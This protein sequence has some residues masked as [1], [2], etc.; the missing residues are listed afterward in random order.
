MGSRNVSNM[1]SLCQKNIETH[2]MDNLM[3]VAETKIKARYSI[4]RDAI[5]AANRFG[6]QSKQNP[7][8]V[9]QLQLVQ[10]MNQRYDEAQ[11]RNPA[12]RAITLE[13]DAKRAWRL[14]SSESRQ[15]LN[16]PSGK[17][18]WPG[19]EDTQ[20][21]SPTWAYADPSTGT[22]ELVFLGIGRPAFSQKGQKAGIIRDLKLFSGILYARSMG[23]TNITSSFYYL[24]KTTDNMNNVV[25]TFDPDFFSNTGGN[26]VSLHDTYK[27]VPNETDKL[28]ANALEQLKV[29]IDPEAMKEEDCEKCPKFDICQYTLP[30]TALIQEEVAVKDLSNLHLTNDQIAAI[31]VTNGVWRINAGAGAGKTMV[32]A[33]RV[34]KLLDAGVQP[35]EILLITFTT[36]GAKEMRER[37]KLVQEQIGNNPVEN[38]DE[39]TIC[40]F[41]AFGDLIIGDHYDLLGY[42][43]KPRVINDVN[44][45][46]IIDRLLRDHP[47]TSWTGSG[48]MQYDNTQNRNSALKVIS[49]IFGRIR[50]MNVDAAQVTWNDIMDVCQGTDITSHAAQE[51]IN[52]Y[53]FYADELKKQGLI[54]FVDQENFP[55]TIMELDPAY[56]SNR[57]FFKHIIVDEFQDSNEQQINLLKELIKLPTYQSL[58]VVGDDSQA[59]YGFRDTSPEYIIHFDKWIGQ[60]VNDIFLTDNHRSTPEIIDFANTINDLN[61]DKVEKKLVATR[62]HGQPVIVNA[63]YKKDEETNFIVQTIVNKLKDGVK[64]EQ[65][66]IICKTKREL[67]LYADLLTKAQVPAV[68]LAPERLMSNSRI[69]AILAF[70]RALQDKQDTR[71][72]LI[73]ANS[74]V[75]GAIMD[76]PQTK[77]DQLLTSLEQR[78]DTINAARSMQAKK[79]GFF[80][81]I[82]AIS[83]DDETV[84][85]F[86]ETLDMM[87][88]GEILQYCSDFDIFGNDVEYRRINN[89]PGVALVTAHS[90]KGLEWPIVFNSLSQY[91]NAR[92]K[93][94]EETR[95]L[96]FVSATRARDELYV[97]GCYTVYGSSY[98]KRV[99]NNYL[100][101]CF[102]A[103]GKVFAPTYSK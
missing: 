103:V 24:V 83:M 5:M 76:L 39:I 54:E 78:I 21:V 67:Q 69:R 7:M 58:M 20:D 4:L 81:Y 2:E 97:S 9:T 38:I 51:V 84:A 48:M 56:L 44:R 65:I 70:A 68:L 57:F 50:Q 28:I 85:N 100:K 72:R 49:A 98:D 41:N 32:T 62:P 94:D 55:F 14:V 53:P 36:A 102:D 61:K 101:E 26:I 80:R 66:A 13:Y 99:Y 45:Y 1:S 95:R 12:Q 34:S 15:M 82:D 73:A 60:P 42:Q 89:Y 63:F 11:F 31:N 25:A 17:I 37:I 16:I 30:P 33:L 71:D 52:L 22:I 8:G 64:P 77:I 27:G 59:I 92:S 88:Y 43:R 18:V 3:R 6:I 93:I 23:Y 86:K 19:T 40:T 74:I 90:S 91:Q 79:E 75:G 29:G 87:D 47:I 96:V 10:Y 35:S 46:G